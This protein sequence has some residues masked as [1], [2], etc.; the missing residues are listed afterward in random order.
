M[1]DSFEPNI[2]YTIIFFHSTKKI[3]LNGSSCIKSRNPQCRVLFLSDPFLLTPKTIQNPENIV[4]LVIFVLK[5]GI[6]LIG[7]KEPQKTLSNVCGL[8]VTKLLEE[9]PMQGMPGLK[10]GRIEVPYPIIQGGMAIRIST[11]RLAAAVATEGGIGVIAGTAMSP[12]ELKKEIAAARDMIK[13]NGALGVNILFA[14]SD[15][16]E[17]VKTAMAAG[18]DMFTSGAGISRDMYA[19]GRKY[20][21]EVVPMVSSGRLAKMAER[22]GASAVVVEGVEAGG[23]LGTNRSVKEVLAEVIQAVKI[24]VIAAGGI[25]TGADIYHFLQ[26]GAQGVQMATRFAASEECNAAPEFKQYYLDAK[27]EDSVFIQSCVGLPGRALLSPLSRKIIA[28]EKV[29]SGNCSECLKKCS[30]SFCIRRALI[31]AQTGNIEEG[32]IFSGQRVGEIKDI[33]SVSAIFKRLKAEFAAEQ[34]R[35]EN[36]TN[37]C[38]QQTNEKQA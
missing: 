33:L 22:L 35:C 34:E 28:G 38:S 37:N 17:I 13:G 2:F 4:L 32:L 9:K 20:G 19:W 1:R 26:R 31:A 8:G 16:A 12:A 11:S 18:I 3:E 10:I 23:H 29:F 15:F 36:K 24:P 21:V 7:Y 27:P 6:L 25:L 5:S 14:V 30:Q